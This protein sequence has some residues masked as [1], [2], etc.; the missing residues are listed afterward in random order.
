MLAIIPARGGSKGLPGK[1]IKPLCGKP[2]IAYTIE[3][4]LKSQYIKQVIVSTDNY[5]I[6]KIAEE[7]NA[8]VPFL[9]PKYLATDKSLAIDNYIDIITKLDT[10]ENPINNFIVLQPTS[11]LRT[12][13][14]IDNA[15]KLFKE[16]DADSVIS[17]TENT[18]PVYWNKIINDDLSFSNIFDDKIAN[19]QDFR[20]TYIPNGAIYIFKTELIKR[21]LYYSKKSFAYIMDRIS[22]I[23][24]DNLED[25]EYAEFIICKTKNKQKQ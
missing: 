14:D 7:Y 1:N 24:I 5:D 12:S 9:R 19:R 18:H 22:S 11:P 23:D 15:I 21:K 16:K 25:F 3:A 20:K 6:K 2:L 8:M 10:I 13:N 17:Y 4:A